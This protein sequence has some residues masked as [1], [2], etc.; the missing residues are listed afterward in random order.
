M[1]EVK[2]PK[3]TKGQFRTIV[4]LDD[5]ELKNNRNYLKSIYSTHSHLISD[6]CHG[7]V[8]GKNAVTNAQQHVKYRYSLCLDLKDFFDSVKP[9]HVS[10]I[11][12]DKIIHFFYKDRAAQGMPSS[13]FIANLAARN[14]DE[15]IL[16]KLP[17]QAVYTRYADD[18]T[19]SFNDINQL[20]KI[21]NVITTNVGRNGFKINKSKTRL[22][23]GGYYNRVITGVSIPRNSH[24]LEYV[25]LKPTRASRRKL[26]AAKHNVQKTKTKIFFQGRD[27]KSVV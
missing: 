25:E 9:E 22:L 3:K 4:V 12:G 5:E 13:P 16:S 8:V 21:K 10:K 19:V 20:D 17:D 7:F 18:L 27:R 2:I 26:R 24:K 15:G 23:D 6:C 1:K 11:L 14:M